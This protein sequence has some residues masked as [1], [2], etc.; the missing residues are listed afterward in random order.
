MVAP[1]HNN[2]NVPLI[3]IVIFCKLGKHI[4][5]IGDFSGFLEGFSTFLTP[6]VSAPQNGRLCVLSALKN[7]LLL[8]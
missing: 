2:T 4:I 8:N 7:N 3:I 5:G 1:I 6:K